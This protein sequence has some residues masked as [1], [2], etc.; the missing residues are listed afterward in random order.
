MSDEVSANSRCQWPA[1]CAWSSGFRPMASATLRAEISRRVV[2]TPMAERSPEIAGAEN[3]SNRSVT[4][5]IGREGRS[6]GGRR[7]QS[8]AH[9]NA[10][11]STAIP[12][13][14]SRRAHWLQT[15]PVGLHSVHGM[16][17]CRRIPA[18]VFQP[19]DFR[20]FPRLKRMP[21]SARRD[22]TTFICR[23]H[24]TI[25][26]GSGGSPH[27]ARNEAFPTQRS[28]ERRPGDRPYGLLR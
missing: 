24:H 23:R 22:L 20:D 21:E 6:G 13:P 3:S 19:N 18:I 14:P 27:G 25:L 26:V 10:C 8:T 4:C 9:T 11:S 16:M 1:E 12:L 28:T 17:T 15:Q 7:T 5:G 2:W